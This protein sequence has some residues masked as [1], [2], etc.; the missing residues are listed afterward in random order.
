ML[1]RDVM[2]TDV[3]VVQRNSSS[4]EVARILLATHVS[5]VPVVDAGGVPIG[6]VSEWDLVGLQATD[7]TAKRELWL[8]HLAEGQPLAADFLQSVD[9][10][11]RTA[12]EIMHQPVIAVAETTPITEV[13]RLIAEHRIK[14]V[15]VTRD[16]RLVGVVSRIDLVRAYAAKA[17]P[18]TLRPLRAPIDPRPA[19]ATT[20]SLPPSAPASDKPTPAPTNGPS[21][22]E[23]DALVAAAEQAERAQRA[24]AER[25]AS[26]ARRAQVTALQQKSLDQATWQSLIERA[27]SAAKRGSRELLLIRFPSELCSDRGRAINVAD[28]LW[29]ETLS[30]EAAD[31]FERWQ[32]ELKPQ[33]FG[34]AAQILDFPGGFPGDAGL[35]LKW[36]R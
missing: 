33:G 30:G 7:R 18:T 24:A 20:R 36:G 9:P 12:A 15:F 5:A 19:V 22:A 25:M 34:L 23:F 26:D 21:A 3:S 6:V 16:D 4:A 1:A 35:T 2:T 27:R 14:R 11:N 17:E 28:P 31:V 29:P 8:S 10:T 13:A 32:R